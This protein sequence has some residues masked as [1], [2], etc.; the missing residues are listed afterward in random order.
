MIR[1]MKCQT[2]LLPKNDQF[3]ATKL[4]NWQSA[5]PTTWPLALLI[6]LFF[7]VPNLSAK[8]PN[9]VLIM[10]DDMGYE[11]VNANGGTT[12]KTPNLDRLAKQG[13]RFENCHSQP[14][15]TPSRVQIMT[16]IYNHRNYIKFGLLDP[17]AVTF[18]NVLK[19]AGYKTCVAGK[20][21]L[22]GGPEGPKNF[23][24]DEHCL[25]QLFRLPSRYPNPG[26]EI[27]GEPVD[28]KDGKYGPDIAS[29]FI[30]DFIERNKDEKFF[31]YYPMILPHWPFE[32]TPDSDD[33]D[34]KSKGLKGIGKKKYFSD[35]VSYTDKVVGKITR[36]L[37]SLGL[38]EN[39]L[40]LFT[41]DN[42]TYKSIQ[43]TLNQKPYMG[44]KGSPRDNG[45]HV[46]MFA[47]WPG[48]IK[49][50]TVNSNMV[51]FSDYFPTLVEVSGSKSSPNAIDG[52]SFAKQLLG[53]KGAPKREWVYCWYE[54]NGVRQKASQHIRNQQYKLYSNGKFFDVKNDIAEKTPLNVMQL[55]A[56]QT[57]TY[58]EFKSRLDEKV[59]EAKA[60]DSKIKM[61]Q[62]KFKKKPKSK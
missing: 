10:A 14:I 51:D 39:T 22:L 62:S 61:K 16:G 13:M 54:R 37:D 41:G 24:F 34:P 47:S 32:P 9:I 60:A 31:A 8:D 36:K 56:E 52:I 2:C 50:G 26:F 17:E 6:A 57:K 1:I 11:C 45:T 58:Q 5:G 55:S 59:K 29:D 30:C 40:V 38:R 28:F 43:S 7:F 3:T 53:E 23:G 21:Q 49:S 46:P 25:W 27:N 42:G 33:W 35:M 44:G 12:Y 48:T 4:V 19:N 18:G 20:W 15:C